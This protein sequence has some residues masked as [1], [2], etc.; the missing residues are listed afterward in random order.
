M[1]KRDVKL[2]RKENLIK[3]MTPDNSAKNV[4]II[5]IVFLFIFFGAIYGKQALFWFISS[6][7]IKQQPVVVSDPLANSIKLI[8]LKYSWETITITQKQQLYLNLH[9]TNN[10]DKVI[11][12]IEVICIPDYGTPVIEPYKVTI[13][14]TIPPHTTRDIS[15]Y[16][17]GQL[18]DRVKN[19]QCTIH[20][21][22]FNNS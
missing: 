3:R 7:P 10:N 12:S 19:V 17:F 8:D 1:E 4:A 11:K 22:A 21:I 18:T 9:L 6:L 20:D 5:T 14:E 2:I 16:N 13:F 15:Q